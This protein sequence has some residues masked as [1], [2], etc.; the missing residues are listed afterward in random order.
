[1]RR[2]AAGEATKFDGLLHKGLPLRVLSDNDLILK[3]DGFYDTE[4]DEG[5]D[6]EQ[7]MQLCRYLSMAISA[8]VE[9]G[10]DEVEA[11]LADLS[12]RCELKYGVNPHE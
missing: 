11:E 10:D 2:V 7:A 8:A 12:D 9:L 5:P 6:K 1:V 3:D 4:G